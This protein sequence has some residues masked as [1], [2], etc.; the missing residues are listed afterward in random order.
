MAFGEGFES[1]LGAAR[2]GAEWAWTA[3]YRELAPSLLAYLRASGAPDP[4]NV[5]GD[6]FL[7][8]VQG[9]RG[10]EGGEAAFRAWVF[11]I[12][13]NRLIDDHRYRARR[14]VQPVSPDVLRDAGLL[15]DSEE[16]ALWA[17]GEIRVRAVLSRLSPDQRDVLLLRILGDLTIDEV[18]TAI[19]KRPGA[20][21][22]LQARGLASLRRQISGEAVSL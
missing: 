9:I 22:A 21:K 15:G 20:V 4:E 2:G 11:A 16:E 18:A 12:A 5:L 3:V 17:L 10:F 8:V 6:S 1:I 14:P 19:G 7:H 13:R